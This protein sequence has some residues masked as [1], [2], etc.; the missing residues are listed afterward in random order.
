MFTLHIVPTLG[1]GT[2]RSPPQHQLGT[3]G[4][5]SIGQVCGAARKLVEQDLAGMAFVVAFAGAYLGYEA[6]H[7]REHTHPGSGS[8]GRFLR[9]HHFYHHFSDPAFNH[10]VT[11]PLWDWVF[12][13]LRPVGVVRVPP[14][15]AMHWLVDPETSEVRPEYA[16]HYQLLSARS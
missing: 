14:K 6:M 2:M 5:R 4:T 15:L 16:E 13:T 1:D 11:S 12:G 7:R 10:G 3:T 9:R 8:F